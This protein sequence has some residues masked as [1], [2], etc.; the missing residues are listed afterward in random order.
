M[1]GRGAV[2]PPAFERGMF[3]TAGLD[4][5]LLIWAAMALQRLVEEALCRS[6]SP[7]LAEEELDRIPNAVDGA[8]EIH[9]G[10][11]KEPWG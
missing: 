7:Q 2:M 11:W 4:F 6:E 1:A 9:P 8:V 5:F 10:E 3:M